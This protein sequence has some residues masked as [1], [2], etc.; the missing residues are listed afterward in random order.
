MGS[1][2]GAAVGTCAPISPSSRRVAQNVRK[3]QETFLTARRRLCVKR[4]ANM[5]MFLSVQ[6][7]ELLTVARNFLTLARAR[8][9]RLESLLVTPL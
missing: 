2:D 3:V 6:S 4:V 9:L 8:V 7:L 5:R 1:D